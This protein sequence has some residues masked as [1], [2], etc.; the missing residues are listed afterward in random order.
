MAPYFGTLYYIS[1]LGLSEYK[2]VLLP[3]VPLLNPKSTTFSPFL[4]VQSLQEIEA[5]K[6]FFRV[7]VP[8]QIPYFWT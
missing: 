1:F 8:V 6:K 4:P 3:L 2:V 5:K 7:F